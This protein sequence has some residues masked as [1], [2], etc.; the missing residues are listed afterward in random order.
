VKEAMTEVPK[1]VYDR[2]RAAAE[3]VG[4]EQPHP[5]ADLLAGFAEQS[6][7]A[8]E[9]DGILGHLGRCGDCREVVAL[10]LPPEIAVAPIG[11][12]IEADQAEMI[13][14]K[15]RKGWLITSKFAWPG[16]R[17]AALATGVAVAVSLLVVHPRKLNQAM[18]PSAKPQASTQTSTTAQTKPD[19]QIA[20]SPTDQ[21]AAVETTNAVVANVVGNNVKAQPDPQQQAKAL[22]SGRSAAPSQQMAA[23][24]LIANNRIKSNKLTYDK[25]DAIRLNKSQGAPWARAQAFDEETA[26]QKINDQ[27]VS[28]QNETVVVEASAPS[29]DAPST[30]TNLQPSPEGSLSLSSSSRAQNQAPAVEKAKPVPQQV[31][32]ESASVQITAAAAGARP[33]PMEARNMAKL[34]LPLSQASVPNVTWT[35]KAGVLQRSLDS[36]QSWQNAWHADHSLLCVANHDNDVWAGGKAGTLFHSSDGGLTWVHVQ[37]AIDAQQLSADI[38]RLDLREYDPVGNARVIP[39]LIVTASNNELWSSADNGKTWNKK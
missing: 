2:L 33:V 39:E 24:T 13:P 26:G 11:E 22:K 7:S 8:S 36:G 6:L 19:A 25:K 10:A 18:L 3:P 9:R 32:T 4:Q 38:L 1:I 20:P 21:L 27:G 14:A 5:D 30:D 15:S 23:G 35:I 17:W 29:T 34:A 16:L 12:E 31:E 37:P 28:H